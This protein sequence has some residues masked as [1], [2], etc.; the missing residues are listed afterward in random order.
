M[1]ETQFYAV[2]LGGIVSLMVMFRL[3]Q[4]VASY[5]GSQLHL[6]FLR[7]LRYRSLFTDRQWLDVTRLQFLMLII[8]L[9]GNGLALFWSPFILRDLE[10]RAAILG[11][12]NFCL[13]FYNGSTNIFADWLGI[14]FTSHAAAHRWIGRTA[15][16]EAILHGAIVLK[17]RPR[18]GDIVVSGASVSY[19]S[20]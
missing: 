11:L 5:A 1:D 7:H 16:L 6:F 13:I 20:F 17:L 10:Q 9:T 4:T 14:S 3:K 12:V 18:P 2:I 15:A 8:Y 19:R